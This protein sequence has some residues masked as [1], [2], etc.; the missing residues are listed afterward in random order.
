MVDAMLL[1]DATR[2]RNHGG[3]DRIW[4]LVAPCDPCGPPHSAIA[5]SRRSGTTLL[6][7]Q[8]PASEAQ[9]NALKVSRVL[10]SE[11]IGILRIEHGLLGRV[12]ARQIPAGTKLRSTARGAPKATRLAPG[13]RRGQATGERSAGAEQALRALLSFDLSQGT[14]RAQL[15]AR[16]HGL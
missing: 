11:G 4:S 5:R 15:A 12:S 14:L 3:T 7:R 13:G 9:L 10:G 1:E 2:S 8:L 6:D 16:G